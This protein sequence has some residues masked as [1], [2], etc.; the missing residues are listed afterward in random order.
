[1]RLI[2][3]KNGPATFQ[4]AMDVILPT[5]KTKFAIVYE[6]NLIIFSKT[7]EPRLGHSKE[8]MSVRKNAG[9]TIN[10]KTFF[11]Q[12]SIDNLRLVIV[13][14]KLQV[15]QKTLQ[16]V[17][18]VFREMVADNPTFTCGSEHFFRIHLPLFKWWCVHDMDA[19]VMHLK[20]SKD[21]NIFQSEK[22]NAAIH[23]Q[24]GNLYFEK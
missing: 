19:S 21:F 20:K 18:S 8:I 4:R 23:S 24:D 12:E 22:W 6:G 11:F 9:E 5:V 16:A 7:P 13:P 14:G 3:L 10:L 17:V 15:A 1:M 2:G